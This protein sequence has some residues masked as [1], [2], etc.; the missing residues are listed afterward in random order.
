MIA[1]LLLGIPGLLNSIVGYLQKR[2]DADVTKYTT[3]V[4]ADTQV[5]LAQVNADLERQRLTN[6]RR[7]DDRGSLWTAWMLPTAFGLVLFHYGAVIFDS[8]PLFG[9]V[10]GS[11]GIAALPGWM[12]EAEQTILLSAAGVV[13]VSRLARMFQR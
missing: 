2:A 12:A 4:Q 7:K 11:W 9:H 8:V 6:E 13:G 3:G 1:T 10:V 5:I